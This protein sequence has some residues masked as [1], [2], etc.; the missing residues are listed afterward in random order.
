MKSNEPALGGFPL[1]LS[2]RE[3]YALLRILN[4]YQHDH[5]RCESVLDAMSFSQLV[6][7]K[8][9]DVQRESLRRES[10]G[11]NVREYIAN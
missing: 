6:R 10:E 1:H 5:P 7:A 2:T 4:R 9:E 11:V 3:A 8:L